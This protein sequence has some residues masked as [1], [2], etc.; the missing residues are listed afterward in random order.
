MSHEEYSYRA[1]RN[2]TTFCYHIQ[3]KI[4]INSEK[5]SLHDLYILNMK[6]NNIVNLFEE[7]TDQCAA[8]ETEKGIWHLENEVIFLH[9]FIF[10]VFAILFVSFQFSQRLKY[11][12]FL[13][14]LSSANGV[15]LK[16]EIGNHNWRMG[17]L[18]VCKTRISL[19]DLNLVIM[20]KVCIH[21][22]QLNL[23]SN[24]YVRSPEFTLVHSISN[25]CCKLQY[26]I[27]VGS[28]SL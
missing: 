16:I 13:E 25:R 9:S 1:S 4:L 19:F 20:V 8:K 2:L 10:K 23:K 5:K 26:L 6:N 27:S 7:V 11:L 12:A 28:Y 21:A 22:V 3:N 14:S 15:L 17:L 24:N 18:R